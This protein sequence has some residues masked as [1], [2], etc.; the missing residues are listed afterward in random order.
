[1]P[2]PPGGGPLACPQR[3]AENCDLAG[4]FYA[5][6]ERGGYSPVQS[7]SARAR[8]GP[9][10]ARC[11]PLGVPPRRRSFRSAAGELCVLRQRDWLETHYDIFHY[12]DRNGAEANLILQTPRDR[13]GRGG[14]RSRSCRAPFQTPKGP[15]RQAGRRVH[16]RNRFDHRRGA[17]ARRPS[18]GAARLVALDARRLG[19][20]IPARLGVGRPRICACSPIGL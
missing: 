8:G 3:F 14:C 15:P 5:A 13:R 19:S 2:S 17:P 7:A 11:R 4:F 1:M 10:G 9:D 6:L 18:G 20:T 12:R 16:R